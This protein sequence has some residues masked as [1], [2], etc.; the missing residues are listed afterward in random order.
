[1]YCIEMCV[2]VG[3]MFLA[4]YALE[5]AILSDQSFSMRNFDLCLYNLVFNIHLWR[6]NYK[7]HCFTSVFC[8]R[9]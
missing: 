8:D 5:M 6:Y 9:L 4:L 1:M 7:D 3:R 2:A